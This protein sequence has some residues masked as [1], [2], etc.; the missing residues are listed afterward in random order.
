MLRTPWYSSSYAGLLN[1]AD[2][3]PYGPGLS[4]SYGAQHLLGQKQYELSSHLGNVQATVSDKRYGIDLNSDGQRDRWGSVH[5]SIYDYYPYGM[6][7]PERTTRDTSSQCVVVTQ[8]KYVPTLT[9]IP[10]NVSAGVLALT[11]GLPGSGVTYT[12]GGGVLLSTSGANQG[13]LISLPSYAGQVNTFINSISGGAFSLSVVQGTN[14]LTST[15]VDVSGVD[16][17]LVYTGMSGGGSVHLKIIA[18]SGGVPSIDVLASRWVTT[19]TPQSVLATVCNGV[20]DKYR[21]GFDGQHKTNE[22]AGI[23]NHNTALFW[24]YDARLGRRWNVD[25]KSTPGISPYSCFNGNPIYKV[26]LLGDT[27]T[28]AEALAMAAHVY[29]DAKNSMLRGGW[30]ESQKDFALKYK[31]DRIGF[32]SKLYERTKADGTAEYSYVTAGTDGSSKDDWETNVMQGAGFSTGQYRLSMRNAKSLTHHLAGAELTFVGHSLGGGEAAANAYATG[33]DAITFNAA[34][35][36]ANTI[37]PNPQ[38]H[39]TAYIMTTDPLNKIQNGDTRLGRAM[40]DV[41]GTRVYVSPVTLMGVANGHSVNNFFDS[42]HV[43]RIPFVGTL[44]FVPSTLD[45][46][47]PQTIPLPKFN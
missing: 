3:N 12:S 33:L 30:H 15:V 45:N 5:P 25:P 39:I 14:V 27:P 31:D 41:N 32:K 43:P 35:V 29:G 26:D 18:L 42:F 6:L 21:F 10:F 1:I 4:S 44:L 7:I 36:S 46:F 37:E 13:V 22:I 17:P 2:L 24:E 19:W 40:P 28:K 11:G 8:T 38:S 34:G 47:K 16:V 9:K 23:G 20:E